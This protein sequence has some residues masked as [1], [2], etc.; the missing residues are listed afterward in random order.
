MNAKIW[1]NFIKD[2]YFEMFF[3]CRLQSG[4]LKLGKL[5]IISAIGLPWTTRYISTK[6]WKVWHSLTQNDT[7]WPQNR[8]RMTHFDKKWFQ[9][10]QRC[11]KWYCLVFGGHKWVI[12][13]ILWCKYQKLTNISPQVG[14][15]ILLRFL[16]SFGS[17]GQ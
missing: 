8:H 3:S 6:S 13:L 12:K 1:S 9:Y 7:E 4:P 16:S 17:P 2:A 10:S 15:E 11:L 5:V 14:S